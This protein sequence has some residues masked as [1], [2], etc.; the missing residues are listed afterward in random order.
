MLLIIATNLFLVS[1]LNFWINSKD[2]T[3][4]YYYEIYIMILVAC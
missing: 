1:W 2:N 4:S 3:D